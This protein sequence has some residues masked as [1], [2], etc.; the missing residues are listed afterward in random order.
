MTSRAAI[1]HVHWQQKL[2][3]WP[4]L[5]KR[6]SFNII[7]FY[8]FSCS[9]HSSYHTSSYQDMMMTSLCQ[10]MLQTLSSED[11]QLC[12]MKKWIAALLWQTNN[13]SFEMKFQHSVHVQKSKASPILCTGD[14]PTLMYNNYV[15]TCNY[16]A[17][18][19]YTS[20]FNTKKSTITFA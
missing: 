19:N 7:A 16:D 13:D 17:M 8:L 9:Y 11:R 18:F 10:H 4:N 15:S 6:S 3:K 12:N 20:I 1:N 5:L 14:L 2:T